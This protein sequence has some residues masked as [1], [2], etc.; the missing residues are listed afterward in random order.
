MNSDNAFSG[1]LADLLQD[2]SYLSGQWKGYRQRF[3]K[4]GI[5]FNLDYTSDLFSNVSGGI[6]NN[7]VYL[8]N[9][10][11]TLSFE[12]EKLTGWKGTDL[13]FYFLGNHGK[14]PS[15]LVGEVQTLSNIDA[16]NTWKLYEAWIQREF[17]N[18]KLSVLAGLYDL[19]S[20]FDVIE[21][22]GLFINSSFGIGPDYSQ[23]G[24]K[25]P[26]IFPNTSIGLRLKYT[27]NERHNFQFAVLDGVPG[28]PDNPKGTRVVFKKDDGLLL[29]SEW[30][31]FFQSNE[32]SIFNSPKIAIGGWY[33]TGKFNHILRENNLGTPV[34]QIG[35]YGM[36]VLAESKIFSEMDSSNQGL[37]VFS[38]FGYA[39]PNVNQF[40]YYFGAG[41]VYDGIIPGRDNDQAGLA[42]A[43]VINC[44]DFFTS[45][46]HHEKDVNKFESAVELTYLFTLS[47]FVSLQ[48]DI[49]YILN[50]L[51]GEKVSN[52]LAI[53]CRFKILF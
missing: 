7:S 2:R 4:K 32:H 52:A 40:I 34:K 14:S 15:E 27:L 36:Y 51:M 53:G 26:S 28:D 43:T 50:P 42:I 31:Y 10:D 19:N 20:E 41:M 47:S 49:Q 30:K 33:Y 17:L 3:E 21:T 39:D 13:N 23:S 46:N 45:C 25:G 8:D 6:K 9:T 12:M 48:P 24:K 44:K 11:I 1:N 5:I 22:A 37:S 16:Y 29:S 35:N 18:E 38:R